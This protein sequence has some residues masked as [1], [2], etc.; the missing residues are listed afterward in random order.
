VGAIKKKTATK[1]RHSLGRFERKLLFRYTHF[2]RL[3]H[4]GPQRR[5]IKIKS[6][7]KGKEEVKGANTT[8]LT[9]ARSAI[10]TERPTSAHGHRRRGGKN[11]RK[12][13]VPTS[14]VRVKK[15]KK[16]KKKKRKKKNKTK[17]KRK[18]TR[19]KGKEKRKPRNSQSF[20]KP[21]R[22]SDELHTAVEHHKGR[23][24][25]SCGHGMRKTLGEK[26]FAQETDRTLLERPWDGLKKK[27]G[28]K[29]NGSKKKVP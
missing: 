24:T 18:N 3:G 25:E 9:D 19:K 13:W 12:G 6:I 28:A 15:K 26:H 16:K 4:E 27:R 7:G 5:E 22:K 20:S 29:K 1:E 17:E 23:E 10:G 11:L 21:D 14:M 8:E 2:R